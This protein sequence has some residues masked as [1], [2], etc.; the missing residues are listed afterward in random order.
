MKFVL[1]KARNAALCAALCLTLA[2]ADAQTPAPRRPRRPRP[3]D[4]PPATAPA[5]TPA[6]GTKPAPKPGEL[7]AYK[8]VITAEAKSDPGVFTVHRIGDKVYFEIPA[9]QLNKPMLVTSEIAQLPPGMG[10]GGTFAGSRVVRWTRRENK[11][12]MRNVDYSIRVEGDGKAIRRAVEAATLEPILES[13]DIQTE[14]KD[15]AAVIEVTRLF[16]SN[17][18]EFSVSAV[19]GGGGVD[20]SRSYIDNIKSFPTNIEARSLLTFAGGG[21]GIL[22][23]FGGGGGG[24][25]AG[26]VTAL[27]H[28]SMVMLPDKPMQGRLYD[29]RV[30]YFTQGFETYGRP[31]NRAVQQ[32]YIT[33]YNLVKKDPNAAVSEP[34]KPIVYYISRE[35]PEEWHPYLK[36]AVEDWQPA[37]E[38]AGFKTRSSAKRLRQSRKTRTGTRK[39]PA[40]P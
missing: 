2:S 35:V 29:S 5:T 39:T 20:P 22:G 6:D 18:Q 1:N 24:G 16:T 25:A 37:F 40:T 34:V 27:I 4:T 31:E 36:Q 11:I 33:R 12:Y 38:A 32:E 15:K 7:K 8:D 30:G 26:S 17:P 13:Y 14:G 9:N 28:Y 10:Y 3:T 23:R 19:L 21:G